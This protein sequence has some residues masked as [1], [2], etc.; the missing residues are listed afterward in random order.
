[1]PCSH[2]LRERSDCVEM[3]QHWLLPKTNTRLQ[4]S[5][6]TDPQ[7]IEWTICPTSDSIWI[8]SI[9]H[10]WGRF[11]DPSGN[12]KL[13]C[14]EQLKDLQM[15]SNVLFTSM[16]GYNKQTPTHW[17]VEWIL[18]PDAKPA[19]PKISCGLF[20]ILSE[21]I[22]RPYSISVATALRNTWETCWKTAPWPA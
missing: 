11:Q 7:K 14:I 3:S 16:K 1:M 22:W 17:E 4:P 13:D 12:V 2:P 20:W 21:F 10:A 9:Y 5:L 18:G 19:S 6:G 8:N 15:T